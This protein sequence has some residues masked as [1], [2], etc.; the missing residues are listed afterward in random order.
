MQSTTRWRIGRRAVLKVPGAV[1]APAA[2]P[3][4]GHGG[5]RRSPLEADV[6]ILNDEV[7][8]SPAGV[9]SVNGAAL[10]EGGFIQIWGDD[11]E[12][13]FLG[14]TQPALGRR[15]SERLVA[16]VNANEYESGDDH[17]TAA[18]HKDSN[19]N[20]SFDRDAENGNQPSDPA[21]SKHVIH[22]P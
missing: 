20:R 13:Q 12:R 19:G 10:P 9:S 16:A 2:G 7:T 18:S 8:M 11:E 22:E 21:C 15:K 17:L 3:A 6:K 14:A 4:V 5:A 1:I